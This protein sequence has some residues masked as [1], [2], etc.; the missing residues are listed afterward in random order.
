ML[1]A[2]MFLCEQLGILQMDLPDRA[3]KDFEDSS[4]SQS[5]GYLDAQKLAES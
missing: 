3:T 4:A 5:S 1:M 2:L